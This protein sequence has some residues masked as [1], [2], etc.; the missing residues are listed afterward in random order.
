MGQDGL[1][2]AAEYDAE[3]LAPVED[4]TA[5]VELVG[6]VELAGTEEEATDEDGEL[7]APVD[8]PAPDPALNLRT[9]TMSGC[10]KNEVVAD[11]KYAAFPLILAQLQFAVESQVAIK[12]PTQLA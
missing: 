5:A 9:P 11:L 2:G 7:A 8:E 3:G 1:A 4:T 6:T 12:S 10:E